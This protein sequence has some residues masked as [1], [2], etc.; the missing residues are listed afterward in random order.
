MKGIVVSSIRSARRYSASNVRRGLVPVLVIATACRMMSPGQRQVLE[1]D[2]ESFEAIVRSQLTDSAAGSP[3]FLRVDARPGRDDAV[4][5]GTTPE[6]RGIE[7]SDSSSSPDSLARLLGAVEDQRRAILD[8]LKVDGR[9][10]FNYPFCG[11]ARRVSDSAA[12]NGDTKCPP[13]PLRYVT[14]GV[15]YRGAAPVLDKL[16]TPESPVPDS[17]AELW[18]VLVSETNIG[19]GGQQWRQYAWLFRR[20]GASG[21]LVAVERFLVSWAE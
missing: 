13:E 5:T 14:V 17:T 2:A 1:A 12:V 15:P 21:K 8:G 4:L 18:T 20:E 6:R 9:G 16:R 10:P 19:P 3:G 11:G 7:L